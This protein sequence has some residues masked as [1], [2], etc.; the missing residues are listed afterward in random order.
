MVLTGVAGGE[1]FGRDRK[2][3]ARGNIEKRGKIR[4]QGE[5]ESDPT[6]A[7]RG[8][9][10]A[11]AEISGIEIK[12]TL[13]RGVHGGGGGGSEDAKRGRRRKACSKL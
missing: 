1:V 13:L 11:P 10:V 9:H 4:R 8:S 5:N 3:H 12:C 2:Q 7:F 6:D